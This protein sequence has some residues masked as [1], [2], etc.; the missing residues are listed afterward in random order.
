MTPAKSNLLNSKKKPEIL[1]YNSEYF[2]DRENE[3]EK[4]RSKIRAMLNGES[5]DRRTV[6]FRGE[7]GTGKT[8]LLLHLKRNEMPNWNKEIEVLY[9]HFRDYIE[10]QENEF[11]V[12][13]DKLLDNFLEELIAQ[14]KLS[15]PPDAT[16]QEKSYFLMNYL[17][18]HLSYKILV[19][20]LDDVSSAS[21]EFLQSLEEYW[22]KHLAKRR[23][24]LVIMSTRGEMYRWISP[25]LR[26]FV[27]SYE[28]GPFSRE[29]ITDYLEQME[30]YLQAKGDEEGLPY[31]AD[32][33]VYEAGGG[34][35]LSTYW[36]AR[37]GAG[38]VD[39]L[40]ALLLEFIGDA[41]ERER[42]RLYLEALSVLNPWQPTDQRARGFREEEMQQMLPAHPELSSQPWPMPE[43]R[44]VRD[45]LQRYHLLRWDGGYVIDAAIRYPI[46]YALR[47]KKPKTWQQLHDAA[48]RM[49]REWGKK[50]ARYRDYYD[51]LAQLH[52]GQCP[53][54]T[55]TAEASGP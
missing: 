13:R 3:I 14:W 10:K 55:A 32:E 21:P 22:L 12:E 4:V 23:D 6:V 26:L 7:R 31:Q 33:A 20:L 50:F 18:N 29:E 45:T 16:L 43:V 35:A 5:V 52:V 27:E 34:F 46:A 49:Y 30:R 39:A 44:R 15:L 41:H 8:W 25:E 40:I 47:H 9:I 38:K 11:V 24:V 42:I 54:A 51:N 19:I 48:A 1:P 53:E 28:L 37:Y 2:F 17:S 36:L